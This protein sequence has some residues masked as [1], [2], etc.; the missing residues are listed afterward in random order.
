MFQSILT[1]ALRSLVRTKMYS[2]INIMGLAMGLCAC[3]IIALFISDEMSFDRFHTKR[4]RIIRIVQNVERGSVVSNDASTPAP[5]APAVQAN[6]SQA[7][8]VV[9]IMSM[10]TNDQTMQFRAVSTNKRFKETAVVITEPSFFSV[11]SFPLIKG[12]PA[13]ALNLPNS[14][15]LT[16]SAAIKYFGDR[17][18]MG[19]TLK[20]EMGEFTVTG[21]MADIP[22]QSHL[23]PSMLISFA[24]IEKNPGFSWMLPNWFTNAFLT[25]VLVREGTG[26]DAFAKTLKT[27]IEPIMN[28]RLIKDNAKATL[29]VEPLLRIYLYSK[30]T[31]QFSPVG[32]ITVVTVL[33]AIGTVI[34]LL[35]AIN[36]INLATAR[37][38]QRSKEIGIRKTLGAHRGELIIQFLAEAVVTALLAML[39]AGVL[40]EILLPLFGAFTGKTLSLFRVI[41]L[42]IGSTD[43]HVY[44]ATL[45]VVLSIIVGVLA[46]CYPAFILSGFQPVLVLKSLRGTSGSVSLRKALVVLQFTLSSALIIATL[47]V[48]Y[49][50]NYMQTRDLG[51]TKDAV[52]VFDWEF[53]DKARTNA[54]T[55]RTEM[56]KLPFV[57]GVA[58]SS[59]VPTGTR[60][61]WL[62][63]IE[64]SAGQKP[65]NVEIDMFNI[66]DRY[67]Q[68]YGVQIVAGR[69]FYQNEPL[70]TMPTSYGNTVACSEGIIVNETAAKKFGFAS[71][72]DIIGKH[73]TNVYPFDGIIIGVVKDFHSRSLQTAIEPMAFRIFPGQFNFSSIRLKSD[74]ATM[75]AAEMQANLQALE[76]VWSRFVPDF[77]PKYSLLSQRMDAL[78]RV[79]TRLGALLALFAG[80]AIVIA[81]LGLF[82]LS[83]YSAEQ[84][85]KEI[86]IRKVLGASTSGII[87]LLSRE[88][89]LL[90][91]IALMIAMP[92]AWFGTSTWLADFAY[93]IDLSIGIFVGGGMVAILIAFATIA[94]QAYR[95]ATAN[96]VQSLRSE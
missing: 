76:A 29:D 53:N 24:T 94:S 57:A 15:V 63:D 73:V 20:A 31:A 12:N 77:P 8:A 36:F 25:Y 26:V 75:T 10:A 74:K 71:P 88:F 83:T 35:G 13:L 48:Y 43:I 84:R 41:S 87:A 59:A 40:C 56:L 60:G 95:A 23:R 66:D 39:I 32:S 3:T 52:V 81:S 69:S 30:R 82:A 54:E 62:M 67:L 70:Q 47:V 5:L 86:G 9:R 79:E 46:G 37:S 6:I 16:E 45:L 33:G 90:V 92:I 61:T 80:L 64:R 78:Y 58:H 50:L 38:A 65:I 18:P 91:G 11:F 89:L 22:D 49:Q 4:D 17:E 85:T 93:K 96:P 42:P 68:E 55:M 28:Q 72:E 19:E 1:I 21:I 7:E 27:T 51:F 44:S 34:L 2:L 14:I